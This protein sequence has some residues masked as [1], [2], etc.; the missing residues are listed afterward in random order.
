MRKVGLGVVGC[1]FISGIYLKNIQTLFQNAALIGVCDALPGKAQEAAE[2]YG[3]RWY[4]DA[5]ALM[6]DDR[7]ELVLNLTRPAEH[8]PISLM[9]LEAGKHVYSEKPLALSMEDARLLLKEA[10]K[11]A[12]L[13]GCAPDTVL[14]AGIQ[15]AR[16]LID[17]GEIGE[18][19]GAT[20]CLML[21]GHEKW[22]PNPDFYYQSGG[23]PLMD[24]G[25]YYL[26]ALYHLLGPVSSV[27]GMARASFPE[28][29]IQSGS[30]AGEKIKV[31]VD[32]HVSSL[33]RFHSG[34]IAS[35]TMSFDVQAAQM[36]FMEV[37]GSLG[38]L[39]VPDPNTFAGPVKFCPAGSAGFT[40]RPLEFPFTENSRGLGLNDMAG[41]IL[42]GST[43]RASGD[44]AL[45]V[46]EIMSGILEST[47]H[48]VTVK[49]ESR[50][51]R[52][53]PMMQTTTQG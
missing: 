30:R 12:L 20:A 27:T 46:L 17:R 2:L 7:I 13:I 6:Q 4:K 22:H 36:H 25:P 32:T 50:P 48:G 14:G 51:E 35:L 28:R 24:M 53:A 45:H 43:P 19:V 38:T 52:P 29:T 16:R 37:Y 40:E 15:S 23:G 3:V 34:A 10:K 26:T 33:L 39:S 18:I 31:N 47:A 42:N 5:Q 1:G 11:R 41:A 44:I 49:I 8:Y 9:A 21:P